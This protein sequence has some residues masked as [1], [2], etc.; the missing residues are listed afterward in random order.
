MPIATSIATPKKAVLCV[1]TASKLRLMLSTTAAS[2]TPAHRRSSR[3]AGADAEADRGPSGT[4][5][6]AEGGGESGVSA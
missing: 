3:R 2:V 4:A 6:D 5:T 1:V